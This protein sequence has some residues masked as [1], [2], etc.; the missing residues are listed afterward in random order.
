MRARKTR[1]ENGYIRQNQV[2]INLAGYLSKRL[3][4]DCNSIGDGALGIVVGAGPSLDKTLPLLKN[5]F[6]RQKIHIFSMLEEI[7]PN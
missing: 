5:G 3:P 4:D 7:Y 6:H 2:F 1:A